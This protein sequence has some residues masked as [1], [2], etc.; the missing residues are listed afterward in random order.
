M[1]IA[2]GG[3]VCLIYKLSFFTRHVAKDSSLFFLQSL[4]KS[5]HKGVITLAGPRDV[6]VEISGKTI[7]AARKKTHIILRVQRDAECS[8]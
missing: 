4:L 8:L 1:K 6:R 5:W 7:R 2:A 3:G